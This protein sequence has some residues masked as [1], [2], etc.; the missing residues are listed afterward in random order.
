MTAESPS[1]GAAAPWCGAAVL[2]HWGLIRARGRDA[3]SFLQGQLTSD[4]ASLG[5]AEARL[6]G[7]CSPK[8][9]LL[10]SFIVWRPAA[11]E[12]L[13]AC[14]ADLLAATLKRLRMFVLRA[15]CV[16]DDATA[17]L[18]LHGIACA[19]RARAEA[20]LGSAAVQA[21]PW[22][23]I[24]RDDGT[25]L[26]RLPDADGRARWLGAGPSAS[27]ALPALADAAW[28]WL[29]VAGGVAMIQATTADRFVPQMLNYEL[30]GGVDFRKGCYPGQ[31][32]V[33][34]SQ[35]RGTLK[36]R[37]LLFTVD[38]EAQAGQEVFEASD[39]GQ[40]AGQVVNAAAAPDGGM[41]ALV[42]VKIA[43]LDAGMR[44][45]LGS[46]DGPVLRAAAMP[47]A[48]PLHAVDPA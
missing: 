2:S 16:L 7:Y 26:I 15:Q 41:L 3:A 32:I 14:S 18:P 29:E 4:V 8:G 21:A 1:A 22:Q 13:L 43:A 40:P 20:A 36:R 6:A 27:S 23:R 38:A 45:H 48:V 34:R 11:D 44:L 33:A 24:V 19:D 37:S 39:P 31:E 17:E 25:G 5:A 12:L 35:Y 42:E 46:A 30:L 10:A 28:R 47:Y 9:R